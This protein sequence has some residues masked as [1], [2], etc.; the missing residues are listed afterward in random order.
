MD[1]TVI[2]WSFRTYD[3]IIKDQKKM[4][5]RI[6][7][8]IDIGSILNFHDYNANMISILPELITAVRNEG[9]SIEPLNILI[10]RKP[11]V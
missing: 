7:R 9:F 2:G 6:I 5:D 1:Y 10:E 8:K 3:T 4:I 11:Y